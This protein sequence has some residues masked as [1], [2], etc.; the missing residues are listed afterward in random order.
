MRKTAVLLFLFS[1]TLSAV[2]SGCG[3][4]YILSAPDQLASTDGAAVPVARLQRNDFF[5]MAFPVPR[6]PMRFRVYPAGL[7]QKYIESPDPCPNQGPERGCATDKLGYAAV[8]ITM[9]QLP[10]SAKPGKYDLKVTLQDYEGEEE[11]VIVPL[12]VWDPSKPVVAVDMDCLGLSRFGGEG[13]TAAAITRLAKTANILYLTRKSSP[14]Q[15]KYHDRLADFEFPDGPILQWQRER[16]HIVR[17]GKFK[18]PRVIVETRLVSQLSELSQ[19]FP[20]LKVGV[21]NNALAAKAFVDAG[22]KCAIVGNNWLKGSQ[23]MH[24]PSW[25]TMADRGVKVSP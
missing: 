19:T 7:A 21:T 10:V 17:D 3:G 23:L 12:Y 14:T 4:Y 5:V 15:Q 13:D 22:L 6:G 1:L 20:K 9:D 18:L 25:A 11:T 2:S 8:K 24:Y 16:W